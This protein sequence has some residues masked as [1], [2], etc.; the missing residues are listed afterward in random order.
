MQRSRSAIADDAR[1]LLFEI[2]IEWCVFRDF[3]LGVFDSV[4][5]RRC[6]FKFG[7]ARDGVAQF[8]LACFELR[9]DLRIK[10]PGE[11]TVVGFPTIL[12]AE[13]I[14]S[15]LPCILKRAGAVSQLPPLA[16]I[17]DD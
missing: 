15:R 9:P 13:K 7:I 4:V 6:R 11:K 12:D 1:P 8:L 10:Q 14:L 16:P 2:I 17:K 5:S 3:R